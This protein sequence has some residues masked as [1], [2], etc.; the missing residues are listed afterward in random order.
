MKINI[1]DIIHDHID[2]LINHNSRKPSRQD[3][4]IFFFL[5]VIL[6]SILVGREVFLNNEA[7]TI[8]ITALSIL[9][10]LLFNAVVLIFDI[11]HRAPKQKIKNELLGQLITNISYSIVVSVATIVI[12]L[13]SYCQTHVLMFIA[14]WTA[15]SFIFNFFFTVLMVLKRM[16]V[17]FKKEIEDATKA[18]VDAPITTH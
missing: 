6:S 12:S 7:I 11:I 14:N 2:T 16:Y 8:V 13:I 3:Y 17:L 1:I 15:Y 5:P 18:G 9:V 4:F 10:G